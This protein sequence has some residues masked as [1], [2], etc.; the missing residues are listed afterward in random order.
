M[1]DKEKYY[2]GAYKKKHKKKPQLE[3]INKYLG[4]E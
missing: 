1:D 2:G 3:D 4:W